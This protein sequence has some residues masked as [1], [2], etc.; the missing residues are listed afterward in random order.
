MCD[1]RSCRIW[2]RAPLAFI[3]LAGLTPGCQR[4]SDQ[5]IARPASVTPTAQVAPARSHGAP[6]TIKVQGSLLGD[7]QAVVGV[8][9]SGRVHK[10]EVDLG[11]RV[12]HGA[13]LAALDL[14]EFEVKVKQAE[15][16]ET[17]ARAKLGLKPGQD[18]TTLDRTQTPA[19]LQEKALV[20]GARAAYERAFALSR[21]N[22][23]PAEEVQVAHTALKVAEARYNS[24][25]HQ[26]DEQLAVLEMQANRLILRSERSPTPPSRRRSTASSPRAM[27]RLGFSCRSEIRSSL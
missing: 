17:S 10:V 8:K 3:L 11:T 1:V 4:A 22:A 13:R 18:P 12:R 23:I 2:A 7:E 24:A 14:V 9:V 6:Q 15:A 5:T 19:V 20:E 25:L 26:I 21:N 16:E 27:W